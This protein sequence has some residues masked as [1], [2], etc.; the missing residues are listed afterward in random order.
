MSANALPVGIRT[1]IGSRSREIL[2]GWFQACG[3]SYTRDPRKQQA[4]FFGAG[5]AVRWA[6]LGWRKMENRRCRDDGECRKVAGGAGPVLSGPELDQRQPETA[7]RPAAAAWLGRLTGSLWR[8][9]AFGV[10]FG[11][12]MQTTTGIVFL[13]S[14]LVTAGLVRVADVLP[15]ILWANVGAA[16][17]GFAATLNMDAVFML[18]VGVAGICRA[19]IKT[20]PGRPVA[21]L[22]LGVGILVYG[23]DLMQLGAGPLTRLEWVQAGLTL[24]AHWYP[25]AFLVG[26]LLSFVTQSKTAASLLAIALINER[27]GDY[28]VL[29]VQ[30]TMMIIYGANLGSSLARRLLSAGVRGSVRQAVLLPGCLLHPG[31]G[32]VRGV[33]SAG[34]ASGHPA[35]AGAGGAVQRAGGS[36]DGAGVRA[37]QP[38]AGAAGAAA[39]EADQPT[40]GPALSAK[41]GRESGYSQAS[42]PAAAGESAGRPGGD[43]A[44]TGPA[45]ASH[46]PV[47]RGAGAEAR[48]VPGPSWKSG[49]RPTR[50]WPAR[51][52]STPPS[53]PTRPLDEETVSQLTCVQRE[54]TVIGHT[55]ES[56][57]QFLSR[58]LACGPVHRSAGP[59]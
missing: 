41:P 52:P 31:L 1:V 44:R 7:E 57:R 9:C 42:E 2:L 4:E 33:V 12:I 21:S 8:A 14:S 48:E 19:Y 16:L 26:V 59:G 24:L 54:F 38:G 47:P 30:E 23:V 6:G 58:A 43:P 15:V 29:H 46:R 45:G 40:A 13:L 20:H 56:V 28:G 35:G 11:G 55:E 25:L 50:G 10:V 22:V 36:A 51:S 32:P 34:G 49:T 53:A 3:V 18:L 39:A 17:L 5:F 37:A 27:G